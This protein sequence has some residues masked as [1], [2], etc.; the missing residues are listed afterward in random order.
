[1]SIFYIF[2]K[3]WRLILY[4][5]PIIFLILCVFYSYFFMLENFFSYMHLAF[6]FYYASAYN[7]GSIFF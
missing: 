4:I 7:I 2:I 5:L 6:V 1:M 3:M